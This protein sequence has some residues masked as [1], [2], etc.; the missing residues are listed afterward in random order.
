MHIKR[1][2]AKNFKCFLSFDLSLPELTLLTGANSSGK[3]AFINALL[4]PFQ[5]VK[6]PFYLSPNGSYMD[7]G[8]FIE[9]SYRRIRN[10]AIE[11]CL[12]YEADLGEETTFETTWVEDAR[13]SLPLLNRFRGKNKILELSAIREGKSQ[14]YIVNIKVNK[15]AYLKST[16]FKVT[17]SLRPL[18]EKMESDA[19][20]KEVSEV[21]KRLFDINLLTNIEEKK[22]AGIPDIIKTMA[23]STFVSSNLL[24]TFDRLGRSLNYI[25][26]FRLAPERTYYQHPK[27][28]KIGRSGENHIDQIIEWE[29]LKAPQFSLLRDS[30][31]ELGLLSGL[32][33]RPMRGGRI[34][35]SIMPARGGIWSALTDVGFGI[36]QFLPIVVADIQLGKGS[37]LI[38]A[39]PEIHLHPSAQA[40]LGNYFMLR[41][42]K[43]KK[44]YIIET[45][46]EY[47]INRIRLLISK[48]E[49]DP[50]NVALYHFQRKGCD[51]K[52]S[53]VSFTKTGKIEGAPQD[54]FNTY[55][56]DVMDIALSAS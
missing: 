18:F 12:T 51:T 15:E 42:K 48:G 53:P 23:S 38:V 26:S 56:M 25:S 11:L 1:L 24:A 49:L 32:Q 44:R 37:T 10:Q 45:H 29:R 27:T 13:A 22:V 7:M 55:M 46:S 4:A 16:E 52:I 30:L 34:E 33:S 8:D 47:L 54:F 14:H 20:E 9:M 3:S 28:T 43:D 5:S 39:Q 19:D 35:L 6:F 2:W 31:R 21:F 41:A 36:S 17:E 50:S 40:L